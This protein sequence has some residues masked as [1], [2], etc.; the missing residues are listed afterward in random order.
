M[1]GCG[2]GAQ[3]GGSGP[4]R[5][6]SRPS[7]RAASDMSRERRAIAVSFADIRGKETV[8]KLGRQ[9]RPQS[10]S[11]ILANSTYRGPLSELSALLNAAGLIAF[12]TVGGRHFGARHPIVGNCSLA[13]CSHSL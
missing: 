2:L 10:A 1:A 7:R 8:D 6:A 4:D 9:F 13:F 3:P 11:L 12:G 5:V